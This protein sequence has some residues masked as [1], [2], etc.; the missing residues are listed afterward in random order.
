[1]K[2]L[3]SFVVLQTIVI[4]YFAIAAHSEA[5]PDGFVHLSAV[6]PTIIQEMRYYS[7]HNFVGHKING[8]AAPECI[9]TVSA[10]KNLS[11][12]QQEL[13]SLDPPL[14]IKVYDCYRPQR[15][16]DEFYSWSLDPQLTQMQLE[17]YPDLNKSTLFDLGY[18][19]RKSGHSRGSTIDLTLVPYPPPAQPGYKPGM[20]L[21]PCIAPYGVRFDD[22][23]IDMGTGF[24][25]FNELA[26]TSNPNVHG[27]QLENRLLLKRIMNKH[28]FNNYALEWWHYT[29]IDEPFP[30]TYFDFEIT[31][32]LF[33]T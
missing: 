1:M 30:D 31:S 9:L 10:A 18:I 23:S 15:A 24:D 12:V 27:V 32:V 22:N 8:Y 20:P 28:F 21:T 17:F 3:T 11:F 19:A 29:L 4:F 33:T 26:H 6:N 5:L 16:V 7:E 14:S 13:L 25:C 2:H